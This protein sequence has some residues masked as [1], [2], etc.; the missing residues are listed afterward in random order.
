MELGDFRE[1][2]MSDQPPVSTAPDAA[3]YEELVRADRV[4]RLVYTDPQIFAAELS[5]I[6]G[7]VWVFVGHESE[8]PEVHDF[9]AREV[10]GR[11]VILTRDAEGEIHVLMNRCRHRGATVCRQPA[12]RAKRFTCPYHGWAYSNDGALTGVPWPNA[13]GSAFDRTALALHEMRVETHRGFIF[14]TL[15]HD[16]ESLSDYLGPAADVLDVW[17]DRFPG[18]RLVARHG[19]HRLMCKANWKL[20]LDN[21]VDGYHPS[22]SHR[23]LLQM[24]ARHGDGKDMGYFAESPDEGPLYCQYLGNGHLLL[25]QRPAYSGP[26]AFW[27]R[28]RP[29]PGREHVEERVRAE[30]PD[31]ATRLL[32]LSVGAQMNFTIFPNLLLIGNQI[33]VLEPL[34]VDRTV[35]TWYATS[36]DA[37]P[38]EVTTMRMRHQED[39]PSFGEPDDLA[40]FAECQRGL[41]IPEVEWVMMNRGLDAPVAERVDERGVVTAPVTYETAP[42]GYFSYWKKLMQDAADR[43]STSSGSVVTHA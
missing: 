37:L 12:G 21:S 11:P 10:G 25:D 14:G 3:A 32:D 4:H 23:S 39:F 42:R 24:A 6:F 8:I 1:I 34:A 2:P 40:N 35:L 16:A 43:R 29:A 27:D 38:E 20:V 7:R 18:A 13:Y 31:D 41:A 15:N 19:A 33:Q 26:G 22:F 28:Q 36:A 30:Y 17:I 9:R 5:G